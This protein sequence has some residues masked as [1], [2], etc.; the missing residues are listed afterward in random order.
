MSTKKRFVDCMC[1]H[2][3]NA[4]VRIHVCTDVYP[5][6]FERASMEKRT[7][8]QNEE[9]KEKKTNA[10]IIEAQKKRKTYTSSNNGPRGRNKISIGIRNAMYV[11]CGCCR[12]APFNANTQNTKR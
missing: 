10:I 7:E 4:K 6:A 12:C 2:Y 11:M 8:Y 5:I 9:K 1:A 3:N